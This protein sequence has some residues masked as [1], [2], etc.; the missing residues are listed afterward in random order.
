M[1]RS[2]VVVL[3]VMS[4]AYADYSCTTAGADIE[5][6]SKAY[7]DALEEYENASDSDEKESAMDDARYAKSNL[8]FAVSSALRSCEN[9]TTRM[10]GELLNEN[11]SLKN[12]NNQLQQQINNLLA[13]IKSA[14]KH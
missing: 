14:K 4:S 7:D 11:K 1:I 6:Y 10:I 3:M 2:L 13:Q 9:S 5:R 12:R 8:D